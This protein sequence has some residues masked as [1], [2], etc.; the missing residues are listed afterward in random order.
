MEDLRATCDQDGR[1]VFLVTHNPRD[2]TFCD[3]VYFLVD[4]QLDSEHALHGPD[5]QVERIHET[6]AALHI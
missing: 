4:G 1:T 3:T 5:L 2:A 6:L